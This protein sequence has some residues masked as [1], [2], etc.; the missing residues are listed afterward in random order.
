MPRD[1]NDRQREQHYEVLMRLAKSKSWGHG[2]LQA[3]L[4]EVTEAG[5]HTMGIDRVNVWLFETNPTRIR[6]IEHYDRKSGEHASS[7]VEIAAADYPNYFKALLAERTIVADDAHTDPRTREFSKG[8]LDVHG[9]SSMLDAPLHAGGDVI[10]IV[11]YEHV[12]PPR[13]WTAAEQQ[14]A[15]SL[16]DL[17][18][19]AI[20]TSERK[21]AEVAARRSDER[22]RAIITN[23]LDAIVIADDNGIVIDWNPR[24]EHVFGWTYDE[25]L[26]K[27]LYETV[28][29]ERYHAEHREGMANYLAT[30]VGRILNRRVEITARHK[31]GREFPVELAISPVKI[32]DTLIFSAFVRDITDRIRAEEEVRALNV[33]LEDRVKK[34]TAELSDAVHEK[35]ALLQKLQASSVELVDRLCEVE[36]KSAVIRNDLERAQVIQR[37]L[38]PSRPPR[39]DG[40]HVDTLYRP[41]MSVGGDL[42]DITALD[43]GRIVFYVADAAGHGVAAAML[44]VLFKQRLQMSDDRGR[45]LAPAQVLRQ[46]NT[47]IFDDVLSQGLFLT[48][49][50]MV[51]DPTTR[52]MRL[53]SAGHTPVVLR[54]ANGECVLLERTGPALGLVEDTTF[55]E[56]RITLGRGDRMLL[57]TDGLADGLEPGASETFNLLVSALTG[58]AREGPIRLRRLYDDAERRANEANNEAGRDDV[59]L[60][61]IEAND[62][63]STFD[64]DEMAVPHPEAVPTDEPRRTLWM[65]EGEYETHVAVRGSGTWM[66][67]ETFRRIAQSSLDNG[68]QLTVDLAECT[69]L[70][71]SF[72]GTL[73]EMVANHPEAKTPVRSPCDAVRAL[74]V[75]LGLDRVLSAVD[76]ERVEPPCDPV[77][78]TQET[79]VRDS[80]HRLLR[81]HEILSEL[82]DE[83]RDQFLG[84]V[85]ALRAELRNEN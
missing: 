31:N 38:L 79:P 39:L 43:D 15:A 47:Q 32:G 22:T 46:V 81:A 21:Q 24:A 3:S 29:P 85:E 66:Q 17:A 33:E 74:F 28:I 72:L 52:E 71:S 27:T 12:G 70:D 19:L 73:H 53:A 62:G 49:S 14:F 9:I 61:M 7:G 1:A 11:C 13:R 34:R 41:G 51:F 80:Q 78:V 25:V 44:S 67:C 18:A 50:Y 59:T 40:V 37:A 57:Y 82:S 20:E 45:T 83:N 68:K 60:L 6:C 5:S 36:R 10:G 23:A 30:G 42:Y 35:E 75:E 8:Y 48:V 63:P 65:A 4:G 54:R 76:D 26:G 56:H 58:D 16:A 84:V 64:N 2:N 77:P 69:H 55:T